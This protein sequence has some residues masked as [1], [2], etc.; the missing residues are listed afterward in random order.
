MLV[1]TLPSRI[2][3]SGS[4]RSTPTGYMG[5]RMRTLIWSMERGAT[6]ITVATHCSP[7][8]GRL[9]GSAAPVATDRS[10]PS[11]F[12]KLNTAMN[13]AF[14]SATSRGIRC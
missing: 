10:R 5:A 14:P 11:V 7:S 8:I 13:N 12:A 1:D 9:A 3:V 2:R 6:D 4:R